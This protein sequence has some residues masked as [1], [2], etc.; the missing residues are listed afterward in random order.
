MQESLYTNPAGKIIC[1][2]LDGTLS[3]GKFIDDSWE[4]RILDCEVDPEMAIIVSDLHKRGGHIVIWTAR[5]EKYYPETKAWLVKHRIPFL[6]IAMRHKPQTDYYID[7][8]AIN[9]ADLKEYY[10]NK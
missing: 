1:V 4:D 7:D 10:K 2:D 3:H 6:A 8:K 5:Q 9:V